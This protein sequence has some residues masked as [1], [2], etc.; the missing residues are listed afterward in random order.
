MSHTPEITQMLCYSMPVTTPTGRC[1]Q[2]LCFTREEVETQKGQ[3]TIL[4]SLSWGGAELGFHP[5]SA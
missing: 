1:S 2:P 3:A 5:G 4:G